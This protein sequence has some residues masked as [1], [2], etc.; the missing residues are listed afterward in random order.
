M[1]GSLVTGHLRRRLRALSGALTRA[2]V[3][4]EVD[5][6]G[7]FRRALHEA[8]Q[9][10][11]DLAGTFRRSTW[12]ALLAVVIT[13]ILPVYAT[14]FFPPHIHVTG[15]LVVEFYLICLY[16]GAVSLL[17][18][19]HSIA[20]KRALFN[21]TILDYVS[22]TNDPSVLSEWDVYELERETFKQAGGSEPHELDGQPWVPW[23]LGTVYAFTL[24]AP[25]LLAAGPAHASVL[26][27]LGL[28]LAFIWRIEQV[29][30][31]NSAS[32]LWRFLARVLD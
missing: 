16:V 5:E 13:F 17:V 10:C 12:L 32:S 15:K 21:A 9:E 11:R 27:L 23:L 28:G 30:F 7:T 14:F 3:L 26:L 29:G 6:N 31:R 25:A 22:T 24:A 18:F 8:S 4:T 2:A 20:C 1:V 19:Y